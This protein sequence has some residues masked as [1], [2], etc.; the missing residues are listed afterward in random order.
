MQIKSTLYDKRD[1]TNANRVAQNISSALGA[2]I[3]TG[4]PSTSELKWG[5]YT[6]DEHNT[7]VF[8]KDSES[9]KDFDLELYN[10]F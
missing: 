2:F 1:E 5:P 8:D 4:D 3:K 6:K 9:K 10:S 7:M